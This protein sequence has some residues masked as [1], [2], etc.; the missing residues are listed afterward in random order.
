M[1]YVAY[2]FAGVGA[3]WVCVICCLRKRIILAIGIVKEACKAVARMPIIT[4]YPVF[5][6][7]GVEGG[8]E[9][10][11]LNS[12][13]SSNTWVRAGHRRRALPH[14]VDR[15]HDVP[16]VRRRRR[17]GLRLPL[18][19]VL[20]HVL[21][22]ERHV[23]RRCGRAAAAGLRGG[24]LLPLQVLHVRAPRATPRRDRAHPPPPGSRTRAGTT[25][26]PSSS[27]ST[28]SSPGSGPP[29]SSSP[30]A[31]SSSP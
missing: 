2:A 10:G 23:R 16:R 28:C 26:T 17:R 19:V 15:L 1:L 29:S 30:P 20:R 24:R 21:V 7:R 31:S 11:G 18:L 14:P 3:I 12:V 27:R 8:G 6:V 9:R 4:A 25:T 5:Q 22:H 13:Y